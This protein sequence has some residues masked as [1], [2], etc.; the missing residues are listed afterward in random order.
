PGN[1]HHGGG[2]WLPNL[3]WPMYLPELLQGWRGTADDL[4]E[5]LGKLLADFL[6]REALP[7]VRTIRYW[8]S[9]GMIGH[10]GSRT[11]T[12][13]EAYEALAVVI[14]KASGLKLE[15]IQ[16]RVQKLFLTDLRTHG[17]PIFK[18]VQKKRCTAL[19]RALMKSPT[20]PAYAVG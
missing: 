12:E 8:R 6:P 4:V 9:C 17:S 15:A 3:G 7:S 16:E 5:L 19:Y 11:Y 18:A 13:R 20:A 1:A 10:S 2:V 14:L